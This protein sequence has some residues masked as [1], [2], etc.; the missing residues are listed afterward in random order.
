M[1]RLFNGSSDNA[2][3]ALDLSGTALLTVS[4]WLWWDTFA[5]NDDL[6]MEFEIGTTAGS[7]IVNPN[8]SATGDVVVSVGGNTPD[9]NQVR[10][11]RP[12]GAAWHHWCIGMDRG[13]ASQE[14]RFITIDGVSQ[15]LSQTSLLTGNHTDNF[16]NGTLYVMSRS[17]SS[18]F[19]A[20]RMAE[21]AIWQVLLDTDEAAALGKGL[22][23]KLIRPTSRP[24]Y[25]PMIG[26]NSPEIELSFGSEMTLSGTSA[27]EHPRVIYPKRR[28]VFNIPATG[29]RRRRLLLGS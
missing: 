19:G 4:F 13:H 27:T 9:Y 26:R 10:F 12:S 23:P 1:A 5:D 11:T 3:V 7:F 29:N 28:G 20:G 25:W 14:V 2:S 16:A 6:A 8:D 18:L 22:S 24:F 17:G 15:S 21:L